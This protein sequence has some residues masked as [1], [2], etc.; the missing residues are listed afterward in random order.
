MEVKKL[1]SFVILHFLAPRVV[2][3][4]LLLLLSFHG[5]SLF[6]ILTWQRIMKSELL[7]VVRRLLDA[8]RGFRFLIEPEE[9]GTVL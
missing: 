3:R 8:F 7:Y 1:R 6:S 2:G 9:G 5:L 4:T